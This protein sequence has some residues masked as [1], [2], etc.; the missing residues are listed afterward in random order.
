MSI[1]R[2]FNFTATSLSKS[3]SGSSLLKSSIIPLEEVP[4]TVYAI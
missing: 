3:N 1:F 2:F 4:D